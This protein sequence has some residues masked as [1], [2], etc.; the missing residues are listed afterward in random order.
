[1]VRRQPLAANDAQA[2]SGSGSGSGGRGGTDGG[3]LSECVVCLDE[4]RSV[5]LVPCGHLVLC[6]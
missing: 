4:P 6:G 5:L 3:A 2:A 1:M